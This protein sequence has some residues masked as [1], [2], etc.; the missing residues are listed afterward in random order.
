MPPIHPLDPVRA[1]TRLGQ[2]AFRRFGARA[3]RGLPIIAFLI[4]LLVWYV[5]LRPEPPVTIAANSHRL[6]RYHVK[7]SAG[8]FRCGEKTDRIASVHAAAD[9]HGQ[10]NA[11][12]QADAHRE[13]DPHA[14]PS[15]AAHPHG[16]AAGPA[17]A[18]PD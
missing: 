14:A 8:A 16:L 3:R 4:L 12:G 1:L 18:A 13:A 11:H 6:T 7:S 17:Q 2:A 15:S 10:V 5:V 9:A